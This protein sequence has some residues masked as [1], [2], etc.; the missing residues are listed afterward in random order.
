MSKL[1][2]LIKQYCPDGVE[3]KKIKEVYTRLKGSPVTAGI[4]KQIANNNGDIRIFAGGKTVVDARREDIPNANIINVPAVLVQSRGVIDFVYYDKPFTFK[5]EMW[6]YTS[7]VRTPVKFLYYVLKSNIDYFQSRASVTGSLPQIALPVTEDFLIPVP[8]IPIQEEIVRI[9]DAFTKLTAELTAELTAR[10]TQYEYYRDKLLSFD[11]E[12]AIVKRIKDMLD[13]TCGGAAKVEYKPLS[14]IF[15]FKNG[16]T[17][18]KSNPEFWENGTIPW[19]RLEDIRENG[20]V[21]NDAIQHVSSEASKGDVFPADSFIVST[22]AT[23]GEHAWITVPFL[24]NQRFTCLTCKSEWKSK[25][26]LKYIYYVWLCH[27]KWWIFS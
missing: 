3:Y 26:D 17:P 27:T 15:D 18:S 25:L 9:L 11:D 19:F 5:N 2:E 24:A 21:L 7:K 22:S 4:M 16:Y 13:Q 23:I 14:E 20:R 12:T 1:D 6:A 8:P 10:R